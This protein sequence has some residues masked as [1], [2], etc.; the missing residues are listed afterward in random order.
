MSSLRDKKVKPP[1]LAFSAI[2]LVALIG[3]PRAFG[4]SHINLSK[5]YNSP[6]PYLPIPPIIL[7]DLTSLFAR[8][9]EPVTSETTE[10]PNQQDRNILDTVFTLTYPTMTVVY[11]HP[12]LTKTYFRQSL[13]LSDPETPFRYGIYLGMTEKLLISIVGPP[14]GTQDTSANHNLFYR[15]SG[16]P[17]MIDFVVSSEHLASMKL[18][19]DLGG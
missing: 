15:L 9:G 4:Q 18:L 14:D 3:S 2:L 5:L 16:S 19:L 17:T 10:V 1:Q 7:D 13:T 6:Y 8:F 11:F 12:T